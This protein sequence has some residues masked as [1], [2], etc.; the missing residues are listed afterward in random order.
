MLGDVFSSPAQQKKSWKGICCKRVI[1]SVD[2]R[3]GMFA[4]RV[5]SRCLPSKQAAN[6]AC[7]QASIASRLQGGCWL[8][9]TGEG[10]W[11]IVRF[12]IGKGT[13]GKAVFTHE[14][15]HQSKSVIRFVKLETF[16][17]CRNLV[18]DLAAVPDGSSGHRDCFSHWHGLTHLSVHCI[19]APSKRGRHWEIHP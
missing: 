14:G 16:D 5:G 7:K 9:G 2:W 3:P 12:L 13:H 8:G 15:A 18:Q 10:G 4:S 17:G 11:G 6:M 19:R 1:T